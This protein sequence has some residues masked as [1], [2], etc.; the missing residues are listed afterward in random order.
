VAGGWPEGF[1]EAGRRPGRPSERTLALHAESSSILRFEE[2]ANSLAFLSPAERNRLK[3]AGGEIL[4]N[5]VK[6]AAPTGRRMVRI[7]AARR[8]CAVV[9]AFYF[10]SPSFAAFAGVGGAGPAEAEPLFDPAHRRWRG[11]GLLMCRNLA[12]KLSFRPG[13]AM[14]RIYLEFDPSP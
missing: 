3:L 11:I 5:I 7:R 2:F 4:D 1:D 13:E 10:R 8:G 14:D 9:L 6:H 12:R